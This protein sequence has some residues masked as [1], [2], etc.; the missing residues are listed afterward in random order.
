MTEAPTVAAEVAR[1]NHARDIITGSLADV[2]P[3]QQTEAMILAA[4]R[5]IPASCSC[6]WRWDRSELAHVRTIPAADCAWHGLVPWS[7]VRLWG[8][9]NG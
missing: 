7:P 9:D 6:A 3:F 1:V 8:S 2:L 5:D 4:I